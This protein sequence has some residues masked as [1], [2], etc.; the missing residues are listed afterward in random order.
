M[1]AGPKEFS[2][3]LG[4]S[5]LICVLQDLWIH[6]GYVVVWTIMMRPE[7]YHRMYLLGPRFM[8]NS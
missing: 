6:A 2:E 3:E 8:K 7:G 1:V 5:R 4:A